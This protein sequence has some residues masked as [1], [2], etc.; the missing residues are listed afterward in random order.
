MLLAGKSALGVTETDAMKIPTSLAQNANRTNHTQ[1]WSLAG[2]CCVY[3][4][5][6]DRP[7]LSMKMRRA[8][9]RQGTHVE[10]CNGVGMHVGEPYKFQCP[11]VAKAKLFE[12]FCNRRDP[13]NE[14]M[15]IAVGREVAAS[16]GAKSA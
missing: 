2:P 13:E 16:F 10:F 5:I 7:M 15:P 14:Y 8:V 6:K 12:E 3:P 9:A 4:W 11:T 1:A